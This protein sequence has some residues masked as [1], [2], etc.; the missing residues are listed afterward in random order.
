MLVGVQ[1]HHAIAT[2]AD[3]AIQCLVNSGVGLMVSFER[4][5]VIRLVHM[6]TFEHLQDVNVSAA[7]TELMRGT[8]L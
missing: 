3:G 1:K 7:V 2:A 4:Q 8:C 6:E 5:C